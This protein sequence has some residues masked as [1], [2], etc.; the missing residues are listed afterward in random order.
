MAQ[1]KWNNQ[2]CEDFS[3]QNEEDSKWAEEKIRKLVGQKL[4]SNESIIV[5]VKAKG[6]LN[7]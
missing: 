6:A 3:E 2:E 5:E 1:L 7:S 4:V